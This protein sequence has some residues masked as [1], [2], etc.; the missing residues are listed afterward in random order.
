MSVFFRYTIVFAAVLLSFDGGAQSSLRE[1]QISVSSD[2][3]VLDTLSIYPN[4]FE[5]YCGDSK[6]TLDDYS[7]DFA[8]ATLIL[9]TTCSSRFLVKYR[10]LP[11]NLSLVMSV[12]D[13][14]IVYNQNKGP[15]DKFL[16]SNTATNEDIFGGNSLSKT[17]SISRGVTFGNN[18][19]LGVNSTLN[20]ELTGQIAPNLFLLAS[21]SDDNLPIQPDGNT[22]KLQEFDQIFIQISN[23]RLKLIAGDF[24]LN[25]PTGYFMS[26]KKR[27]QGLN[28]NYQWS[29]DTLRSLKTEISGAMSR[30]KYKWN[31]RKPRPI[32]IN[33]K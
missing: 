15:L 32:P 18:Q 4:S 22:N 27:A 19:N 16:F 9:R 25:K 12:R 5:L 10:V 2:T 13:T 3:L 23:D 1:K 6:L 11:M 24:W 31:R 29:K 26:Y 33:W 21:V 28:L 17:G 8:S 7:L 30:G 14:S 20:L